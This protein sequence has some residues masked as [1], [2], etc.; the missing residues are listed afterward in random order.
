MG[1]EHGRCERLAR[2]QVLDGDL[3]DPDTLDGDP[4]HGAVPAVH[5]RVEIGAAHDAVVAMD[6]A[7]FG[8]RRV[9]HPRATHAVARRH[10]IGVGLGV[11]LRTGVVRVRVQDGGIAESTGEPFRVDPGET[12]VGAHEHRRQRDPTVALGGRH[13]RRRRPA[14]A[15][16]RVADDGDGTDVVVVGEFGGEHRHPAVLG[17]L[18]DPVRRLLTDAEHLVLVAMDPDH[19]RGE[20]L[21]AGQVLDRDAIG[22]LRP[23]M[24]VRRGRRSRV[25]DQCDRHGG[26]DPQ[27]PYP[28]TL[29][30]CTSSEGDSGRAPLR[31]PVAALGGALLTRGSVRDGSCHTRNAP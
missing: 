9:A 4:R 14:G 8:Q 10:Q 31:R 24:I 15:D 11:D 19:G 29:H 25:R 26:H 30:A 16:R 6:D 18:L 7:A 20:R 5:R 22:P 3:V 12:V 28:S 13:E 17:E 2:R 23:G 27:D 1:G 21:T